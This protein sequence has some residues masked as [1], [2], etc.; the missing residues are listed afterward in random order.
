[1]VMQNTSLSTSQ[2]VNRGTIADGNVSHLRVCEWVMAKKPKGIAPQAFSW[3]DCAGK[4]RYGLPMGASVQ[5]MCDVCGREL[6]VV[7]DKCKP[8]T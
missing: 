5:Y 1:M 2:D 8:Q 3:W 7:S 6:R 4:R